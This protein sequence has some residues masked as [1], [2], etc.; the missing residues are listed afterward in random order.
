[1]SLSDQEDISNEFSMT[2]SGGTLIMAGNTIGLPADIPKRS[3]ETLMAADLLVFEEDRG[4]RQALKAAGLHRPYLKFSEHHESATLDAVRDALKAKK[5]VCYMSD[6]GMPTWADPGQDLLQI[7]YQLKARVQ[8][9]PG[10]NSIAA[11]LAAC[12]FYF[13]R[14]YFA[15]FLERDPTLRRRQLD[16][17]KDLGV[18]L[19]LMD[20]P[21]RLHALVDDLILTLGGKRQSFLALDISGPS[22]AYVPSSLEGLKARLAS[23]KGKLNFVLVIEGGSQSTSRGAPAKRRDAR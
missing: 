23:W 18:P 14:F 4:A 20:T 1:V 17:L 19:V 3:L 12:P 21:Y 7:A 10:P 11:A 13:G 6:Q 22:E 15:G 8:I 9:I 5:T 2:Y 16:E